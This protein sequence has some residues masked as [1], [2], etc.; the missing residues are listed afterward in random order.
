MAKHWTQTRAGKKRMAELQKARWARIHNG[1]R[2]VPADSLDEFQ[3]MSQVMELW[4]KL[5]PRGRAYLKE[6]I[7]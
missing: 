6:R 5:P 2:S 4:A 1:A 3:V 7:G